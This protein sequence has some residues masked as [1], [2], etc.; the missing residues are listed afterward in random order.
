MC[1]QSIA[2]VRKHHLMSRLHEAHGKRKGEKK[3]F[4]CDW[5][6]GKA[7][8]HHR[9]RQLMHSSAKS[10]APDSLPKGSMDGLS[11][12]VSM[13]RKTIALQTSNRSV[14]LSSGGD[15]AHFQTAL[16][17]VKDFPDLSSHIAIFCLSSHL[18]SSSF[19]S[20]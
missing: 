9:T 3:S 2:P 6:T 14:P 17:L 18:F 8:S 19:I 12:Q 20:H 4:T 15:N 10:Q 13:T 5:R 7:P 1:L 16:S 11:Y